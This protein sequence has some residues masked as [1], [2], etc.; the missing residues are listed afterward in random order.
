MIIPNIENMSGGEFRESHFKLHYPDFYKY[1]ISNFPEDIKFQEKLYWYYNNISNK[2]VCRTCG[3]PVVFENIKKGYRLYCSRK[4]MNSN[5]DKIKQVKDTNIEKYGGIA[6]ICSKEVRKK[7]KKTN[8]ERYG[9]ENVMQNP[10]LVD[11]SINKRIELYG[12]VGNASPESQ[13]KHRNTC[14]CKY[15]VEWVSQTQ[16]F[17]EKVKSTCLDKYGVECPLNVDENKILAK[18]SI[19]T[20]IINQYPDVIGFASDNHWICRCPHPECN[21][22]SEKQYITKSQIYRG[23][24]KDKTELCTNLLPI[25]PNNNKDTSIELFVQNILNRYNIYYIKNDRN[26]LNGREL[27]IYIPTYNIAIECNGIYSHSSKYRD[28]KYHYNKYSDCLEK[29]IQLVTLWEDQIKNKPDIVESL[30]LSKL[31][32]FNER[33]GA[34]KCVIKEVDYKM[35]ND[36]LNENHIQGACQSKIRL[37]LYYKDKLVSVMTFGNPIGCSGNKNNKAHILKRFCSLKHLQIIGG[38]NKLLSYYINTYHP[39]IIES[40]AC[41]DISNGNVYE[42]LGFTKLQH[43]SSY[44]YI[45]NMRR[46]HRSTFTKASIVRMGYKDKVDSSWTEREVMKELG[47][48]RIYDCGQTKYSLKCN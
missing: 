22:C 19:Q 14:L 42:K 15:G 16:E 8:L 21:K 28:S 27:D 9:V 12:G 3:N 44:W 29:G 32:I 23:R 40:F 43:N 46:Y 2:P 13:V 33:I 31:G 5:P 45:K 18:E 7:I 47:Y 36:F 30:L 20:R 11:K 10:E 39:D 4:C 1:I 25:S 34:R 38:A 37:G 35:C 6:P 48:Y 41:N 17:K 24:L 26:V